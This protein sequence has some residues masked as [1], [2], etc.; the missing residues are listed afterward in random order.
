MYF[1][2]FPKIEYPYFDEEE[3]LLTKDAIDI[4]RRIATSRFFKNN[5][6]S[7]TKYTIKDGQRSDLLANALYENSE[8][9]WIFY[10]VNEMI[11]PYFS[12]PLSNNDFWKYMKDKYSGSSIFLTSLWKNTTQIRVCSGKRINELSPEDILFPEPETEE[13]ENSVI[14]KKNFSLPLSTVQG[15]SVGQEVFVFG[16]GGRRLFATRIKTVRPNFYEISVE[17]GDWWGSLSLSRTNY[18]LYE[19]EQFGINYIVRLPISRFISSSEFSV[20]NFVYQ[21]EIVDPK[22]DFDQLV[23]QSGDSDMSQYLFFDLIGSLQG[24][25]KD[26]ETLSVNLNVVP[27]YL[28]SDLG[29]TSFADI[30]ATSTTNN[31]EESLM[32]PDYF[33]THYDYE[34]ELNESKREIVVPTPEAV[35]QIVKRIKEILGG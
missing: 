33:V 7:F 24:Q 15:L 2:N 16:T 17:E 19:F 31:D 28:Y 13:E 26:P 23:N 25:S 32:S 14:F 5:R 30:F 29:L 4:T 21:G 34:L 3:N 20:K 27:N 18:L 10:I 8:L 12:W 11:N 22:Q 35:E 1:K 6:S 9:H